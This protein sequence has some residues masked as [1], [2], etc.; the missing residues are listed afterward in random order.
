MSLPGF[1]YRAS[2]HWTELPALFACMY[3]K[4]TICYWS[5]FLS[6][7]QI[8]SPG[9]L[10]RPVLI[11]SVAENWGGGEMEGWG[12]GGPIIFSPFLFCRKPLFTHVLLAVGARRWIFAVRIHH[13]VY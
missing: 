8:F 9:L 1:F 7:Q 4:E 3:I 12:D 10:T 11:M 5:F 6:K 2:L 13:L